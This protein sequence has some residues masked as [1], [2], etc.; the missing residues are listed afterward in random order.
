MLLLKAGTVNR[1]QKLLSLIAF[2]P[3]ACIDKNLFN[4]NRNC[5]E[6]KQYCVFLRGYK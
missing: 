2:C 5:A 6:R 4:I 3:S 1:D